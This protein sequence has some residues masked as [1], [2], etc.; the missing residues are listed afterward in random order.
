VYVW[1]SYITG[2]S[3][4]YLSGWRGG[5]LVSSSNGSA[6]RDRLSVKP[7]PTGIGVLGL[8]R[9]LVSAWASALDSFCGN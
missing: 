7:S 5:T 2:I 3:T 1:H 4:T 6:D 8:R 9:S